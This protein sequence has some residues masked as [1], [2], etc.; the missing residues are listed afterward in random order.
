[1]AGIIVEV[2]P[3]GVPQA[4]QEGIVPQL[5][6][7]ICT[8]CLIEVGKVVAGLR[9]SLGALSSDEPRAARLLAEELTVALMRGVA[10]GRDNLP[11]GGPVVNLL[12]AISHL[13]DDIQRALQRV[14]DDGPRLEAFQK[15]VQSALQRI[16]ADR[17]TILSLAPIGAKLHKGA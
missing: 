8:H 2:G 9:D 3:V 17:K 14:R 4:R 13:L 10:E 16:T 11:T 1:M 5:E 7:A 6:K 15:A 12:R